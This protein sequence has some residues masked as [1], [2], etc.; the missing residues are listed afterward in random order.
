[1]FTYREELVVEAVPARPLAQWRSRTRD[2]ETGEPRHAE[3]GFLRSVGDDVELAVAH[4]FG[5]VETAVGRWH[6]TSLMLAS[7]G[8][9][10]TPSAKE[11]VEVERRYDLDGDV[12]RYTVSMAA[13][14]EPLTHHLRAELHR[15]DDS[16]TP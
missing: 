2:A 13:V 14:G 1:S 7:G 12:L 10:G 6:G 11:V 16:T 5:V 9:L 15:A 4:G 3:L 8:L